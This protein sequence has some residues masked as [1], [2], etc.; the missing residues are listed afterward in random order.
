M[1]NPAC[2]VKNG[3]AAY[4]GTSGGVNITPAATII[5]RLI[6]TSADSWSIECVYTD[7]TSVAATVTSSLVIDT[8]LRTATFTAPSAGKAYIFRSKVNNGVGADGK[9]KSSYTT[10]FGVY[11]LTAGGDRVVAVNETTEGGAFG[12]ITSINDLIRNPSGGGSVPTGDGFYRV[13]GGVMDPA[14]SAV[15]LAGGATH[16]TGALPGANGGTGKDAAALL[17]NPDKTVVVNPTGT[18]YDFATVVDV[19]SPTGNAGKVLA[20]NAA[21][22]A[23]DFGYD[24]HISN[25]VQTSKPRVGDATPYASEG[26][27]TQAMADANQTLGASVYS[28][29]TVKTTGALTATRTATH[30][31]PASEDASCVKIAQNDCTGDFNT[32]HSTGTGTTCSLPPTAKTLLAFTPDGVSCA[33]NTVQYLQFVGADA[34]RLPDSGYIRVDPYNGRDIIVT[35]TEN[36]SGDLVLLSHWTP[37][38]GKNELAIGNGQAIGTQVSRLV[39]SGADFVRTLAGSYT[40]WRAGSS[41]GVQFHSD[42]EDFGGGS[43]VI[44]I[45]NATTNPTTN[46]TG[47]I[48]LYVDA[49]DNTLKYRQAAG[50]TVTLGGSGGTSFADN[51]F[52]ITDDGDATKKAKFQCSGITT[53]TT[54]TLTV[55]NADGTLAL[56]GLA[57][58]FSALQTFTS[59]IALGATP[60]TTGAVRHPTATGA[61]FRNNANSNNGRIYDTDA[62]D[63]ITIGDTSVVGGLILTTNGNMLTRVGELIAQD[64]GATENRFRVG[65]SLIE[66]G[67]PRVGTTSAPNTAFAS[68]G[69]AT[70][71]M[72]DANQTLAAAIYS[73]RIVKFTGALTA[74][75]TATFPHPASE[76]A[77]YEKLIVN[78]CSGAFNVIV[79]TG[80]GTTVNVANATGRAVLAFTPDGVMQVAV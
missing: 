19:P 65:A 49:A 9:I 24:K 22:T 60:A 53:A 37:A 66:N 26:R 57:Q 78:D 28:R 43:K 25:L 15:N 56:L 23:I 34:S 44:G 40:A 1:P 32:V 36:D 75:R 45:D 72:A 76:D 13:T 14:A 3:G 33:I 63:V 5:I 52:E 55:P 11:T 6:D 46:P 29:Q 20:V 51:V 48:V 73:R 31:H 27:A 8:A 80:T 30:P 74:D 64:S 39:L 61:Y 59:N 62:S 70:Q 58:T 17:A 50:T 41:G 68:E 69:R 67:K 21:G 54:R 71:A 38:A 35:R 12:W 4:V 10:T 7:E 16:V 2:E 77:S 79:S 42:T 18:G 47:G